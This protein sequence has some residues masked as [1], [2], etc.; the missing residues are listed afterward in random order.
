MSASENVLAGIAVSKTD[1]TLVNLRSRALDLH[2]RLLEL[3]DSVCMLRDGVGPA[4]N[5]PWFVW[6]NF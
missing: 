4:R 2:A 3:R 1:N 5:A 6:L